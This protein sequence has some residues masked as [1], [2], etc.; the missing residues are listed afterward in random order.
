MVDHFVVG[1]GGAGNGPYHGGGGGAGGV[2]LLPGN[3]RSTSIV[4]LQLLH[5]HRLQLQLVLV[6]LPGMVEHTLVL[7]LV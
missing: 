2:I 5:H 4:R 1:G 3:P 6:V 7:V